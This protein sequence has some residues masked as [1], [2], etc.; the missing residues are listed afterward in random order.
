MPGR[1]DGAVSCDAG[2]RVPARR[3]PLG[4]ERGEGGG[5]KPEHEHDR[6]PQVAPRP[7]EPL[8]ARAERFVRI[9]AVHHECVALLLVAPAADESGG[10]NVPRSG[11][12]TV[13]LSGDPRGAAGTARR[14]H[15]SQQAMRILLLTSLLLTALATTAGAA[16]TRAQEAAITHPTGAGHGRPARHDRRR[17]R[18]RGVQPAR[19]AVV[20]ALRRRHDHRSGRRHPDLSRPRAPAARAQQAQRAPGAGAAEARPEAGLLRP[21]RIDYGD[22]G[23][24]RR[25]GRADDDAAS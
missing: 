22:M 18:A 6:S 3:L 7:W 11:Y 12:D 4:Q 8:D 25:R 21:R 19:N 16:T 13:L 23:D 24:D 1:R 10:H 2:G 5:R 20:H 9:R 15:P 17:L 14:H